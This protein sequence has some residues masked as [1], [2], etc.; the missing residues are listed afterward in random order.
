MLQAEATAWERQDVE[1]G[2][3]RAGQV[4]ERWDITAEGRQKSRED[5]T[6]YL[7]PKFSGKYLEGYNH[8]HH[9]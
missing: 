1:A 5:W 9:G 4:D 2:C 6:I 7:C 8:I 3:L